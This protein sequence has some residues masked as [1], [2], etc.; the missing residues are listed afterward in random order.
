MCLCK[1]HLRNIQKLQDLLRCL[2]QIADVLHEFQHLL[3]LDLFMFDVFD[4]FAFDELT[5]L[6]LLLHSARRYLVSGNVDVIQL[7]FCLQLRTYFDQVLQL[8]VAACKIQVLD[9]VGVYQEFSQVFGDLGIVEVQ[10]G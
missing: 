10:I 4:L 7:L 6:I 3:F 1:P 9:G 8:Q 2:N 5:F